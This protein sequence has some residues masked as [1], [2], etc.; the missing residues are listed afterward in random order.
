MDPDLVQRFNAHYTPE[1][2][3]RVCREMERRCR[4]PAFGFR[5]A[6]LPLIL[7]ADLR[8]RCERA[9]YEILAEIS[10]PSIRAAGEMAIP[11][12][13]RVPRTDA[14]PHF[15]AVDL[16]IVR[17]P[18]G[19]LEP[20]LVELQAFSS[21]YG[22]E[23][24]QGEI[25]GEILASIPGMP[26]RW[27][28]IFGGLGREGY[29]DLL[30]RTVIAGEDPEQVVLLELDPENQKTRA[31]FHVIEEVLGV[32]TVCAT[33][34][35][36]DGRR[37]LAPLGDRWVPIRRIFNRIV[38]DELERAGAALPWSWHDDLDLTWVAHP[39]WYWIWSKHTLPRIRLRWAP[40][41]RYLSEV[42]RVPD[43]LERYVL[44][45]LFSYA[46]SGVVVDLTPDAIRAIPPAARGNWILQEKVEYAP[47]L[48]APDGAGVKGEIRMMF[49]RAEGSDDL[50]L[51][52]NLARLSRGKMHGVDH[53]KGLDWVG[54]SVAVWP[55][56]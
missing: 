11:D 17:G 36:K 47:A 14:L 5:L 4:E 10:R 22:M 51:A 29:V 48:T 13:F 53:N 44:K 31:D 37:L 38:F 2:Y 18:E 12:A 23:L 55:E 21:L 39:N 1:V 30:R 15:L 9:A 20:R 41:T 52:I 49:L 27:T 46:G 8:E 25:W 3:A 45:P 33:K 50:T 35:R 19:D 24:V 28:P 32:R 6:E 7:P 56:G 34:V 43:D 16:A 42:D 26:G 54:S 40:V